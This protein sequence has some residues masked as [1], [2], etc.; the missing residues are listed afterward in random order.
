MKT[1]PK[2][3]RLGLILALFLV[4][5]TVG[6]PVVSAATYQMG[7][8]V[9]DPAGDP[10]EDLVVKVYDNA[11]NHVEDLELGENGTAYTTLDDGLYTIVIDESGYRKIEDK[12]DLQSNSTFVYRTEYSKSASYGMAWF[13]IEDPGSAALWA[14]IAGIIGF[15]IF[16]ALILVVVIK[17]RES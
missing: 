5:I 13:N 15:L 12:I 7:V 4:C 17:L 6:M 2:T 3:Q 10:W 14:W 8:L 16:F 11:G 1:Q 9:Y